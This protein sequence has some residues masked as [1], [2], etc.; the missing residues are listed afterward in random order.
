MEAVAPFVTEEGEDPEIDP[1]TLPQAVPPPL[2]RPSEPPVFRPLRA[3]AF[4]PSRA[5]RAGNV[6]TIPVRYEKLGPGPVGSRVHV[7]DYDAS[8]N[9][10]YDPVDLDDPLIALRGGLDP[11]ESDPRFHQQMVYAV[12]CETLRR[13][14]SALGR[15][16][17]RRTPEGAAP[18][19]LRAYPHVSRLTNAHTDH[20]TGAMVFGY[21]RAVAGATGRTL[22]GQTVFTCLSHDVIA[23]AAMHILV[24]AGIRPD[25]ALTSA[26]DLDAFHEGF[27]DAVALLLHFSYR[28]AVLD[29]IQRTAGSLH[30]ALVHG[31]GGDA[32][33]ASARIQAEVALDNPLLTIG[34]EFAEALG[35]R[36]GL[37]S[38]LGQRPDPSALDTITESHA[39]GA[40]L[41][42]ALFDALFTVYVEKSLDLFRIYRAGG[43]RLEAGDLPAPLVERLFAEIDGV[44]TRVFDTCIQALDYCPPVRFALGDFLR[45]CITADLEAVPADTWGV[46][47]ALM[48]AFRRRGLKPSGASFFSEEALRWPRVDATRLTRPGPALAGLAESDEASSAGNQE[49]LRAFVEENAVALGLSRGAAVD[50]YPLEV[51]RIVGA[52]G[53]V[54]T[55]LV[56]QALEKPRGRGNVTP[57]RGVSLVLDGTGRL[58]YAIPTSPGA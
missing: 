38:A 15:T 23:H 6:M 11:S 45:A 27:S 34:N 32:A 40:I 31:D 13:V 41:L 48:L 30:G 22:P 18:L 7:I 35:Q 16:V 26:V 3:Y 51:S 43:G 29:T 50:V 20:T 5:D 46:R 17:R 56:T 2:R 53:T 21:F 1:S 19:I 55:T 4:D 54:Q 52:D 42:A 58:R 37:R 36:G 8:R 24:R 28:E 10:Y 47:E 39:R 57:A 44:A 14:E 49:A 12:T 33:E 25:L 9:C